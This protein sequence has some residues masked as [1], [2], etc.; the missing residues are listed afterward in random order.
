VPTI[1]DLYAAMLLDAENPCESIEVSPTLYLEFEAWPDA[2]NDMIVTMK[3]SVPTYVLVESPG[4]EIRARRE[5]TLLLTTRTNGQ[6]ARECVRKWV[7]NF[8]AD[9]VPETPTQG[10]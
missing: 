5:L 6:G 9:V 8:R 1:A 2:S 3:N 10:N 4:F 7:A